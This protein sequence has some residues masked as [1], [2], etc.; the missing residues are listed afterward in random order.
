MD[1]QIEFFEQP[2]SAEPECYWDIVIDGQDSKSFYLKHVFSG[3]FL[4]YDEDL[5]TLR[6]QR[7]DD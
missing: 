4:G 7:K 5:E 3:E 1:P 6:I 2:G